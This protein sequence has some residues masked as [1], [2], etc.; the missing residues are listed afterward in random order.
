MGDLT[1]QT[2]LTTY[3]DQLYF[4]DWNTFA[5]EMNAA[6]CLPYQAF[7]GIYLKR[8]SVDGGF[9]LSALFFEKDTAT[10]ST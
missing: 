8:T 2:A 1:P 3:P 9:M 7:T 10:G 4:G 5:P 6:A